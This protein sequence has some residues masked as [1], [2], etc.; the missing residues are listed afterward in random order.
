MEHFDLRAFVNEVYFEMPQDL[1]WYVRRGGK[2]KSVIMAALERL[3]PLMAPVTPHIAEE[4]W[5]R[6]GKKPF[7][8]QVQLPPGSLSDSVIRE[9]AKERLVMRL[10]DDITEILKVTEIKPSKVVVMTSPKWK[11]DMLADALAVTKGRPDTSALIKK[12][13]ASA[14]SAEEKKEIPAYA[15][16]LAMDGAK[17]SPED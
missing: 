14:K 3:A 11:H 13:M 8:S 4:M 15:K 7:V 1:K 10:L 12:A 9:E 16:D 6:I 5:E 17:A 2:N